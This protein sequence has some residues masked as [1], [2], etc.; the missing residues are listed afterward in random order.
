MAKN[1]FRRKH[2]QYTKRFQSIMA[3]ASAQPRYTVPACEEH[4]GNGKAIIFKSEIDFISKCILDYPSIETGGQLFG[5]YTESGTP[6]VLYAIGPGRN[7]N[8]QVA[9]FNQDIEYLT[10]IGAK[11]KDYFGLHHIGEWHSHHQLGL[12]RPSGHD[13][14]TMINTIR[15]KGLGRFLLCIG[16][17][18]GRSTTLNPFPCNNRGYIAGH[19]DVIF[20]D[21]PVRRPADRLMAEDLVMPRTLAASHRDSNLNNVS[22]SKPAYKTG[23]WLEEKANNRALKD[24]LTY[25]QGRNG[26]DIETDIKLDPESR[27][28]IYSHG[29]NRRGKAWSEDI[30]FPMGF[31][32]RRPV[33]S[34]WLDEEVVLM[35]P[36]EWIYSGDILKSFVRYYSNL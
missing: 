25:L 32:E 3:G 22:P 35:N 33:V 24:I 27:V 28:H 31:P 30:L 11:L 7:A 18:D 4:T 8:H 17:C 19:W 5:F 14:S 29:V 23:Y 34:R 2:L 10:K 21:S 1:R 26:A 16:N 6:V 36:V 9:F 20:A 13:A 12:A 15:E